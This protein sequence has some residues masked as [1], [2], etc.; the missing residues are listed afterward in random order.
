MIPTFI[1][2]GLEVPADRPVI[3]L[4]AGG[5]NLRV[6]LVRFDR[7]G[8]PVISQF[9]KHPMPGVE[10]EITADQLFAEL[11]GYLRAVRPQSDRL[12]FSF[13][14]PAEILPSKDGR[15]IMLCK[16]VTVSDA[17]GRVVGESLQAALRGLGLDPG[18]RVVV[19]NDTVGALLAGRAARGGEEFDS[20]IGYI[21]GTGTNCAYVERN[22][23][24]TKR[25]EL[26]RGGTQI[27]NIESGDYA[28]APRGSIDVAFD[29]TTADPGTYFFEKMVS[30]AYL[31]GLCLK[32]LQTAAERGLFTSAA[33]GALLRHAALETRELND[34]LSETPGPTLHAALSP[35]VTHGDAV[36]ARQLVRRIVERAAKFT[37]VVMGAALVRSG[38]GVAPR[39]PV[40]ITAEG[41][42]FYGL[43]GFRNRV[44][45]WLDAFVAPRGIRYRLLA[46]DDAALIGAAVAGLTN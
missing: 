45:R 26:R 22:E 27:I 44:A 8:R 16:E 13:S 29:A 14:Y 40:C 4:D 2:A 36:L 43:L 30:G 6:A 18:L 39:G 34:F 33:G 10:H 35:S 11:A 19:T 7:A 3:A 1:E 23:A 20:Y 37:A 24:I 9:E 38:A 41:S 32:V 46:V 15:I 5:T 12:G 25:P 28:L 31:G 42:T 17:A 21:L